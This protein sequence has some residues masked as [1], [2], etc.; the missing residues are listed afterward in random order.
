MPIFRAIG[1]GVLII[2]LKFL[3][4]SIWNE[5]EAVI[6]AFLH[7]ARV[8]ADLATNLAGAGGA[9]LSLPSATPPFPL[10]YAPLANP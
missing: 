3:V 4:P 1:L 5:L 2:V 7:G 10:P 6:I 9:S 8:S